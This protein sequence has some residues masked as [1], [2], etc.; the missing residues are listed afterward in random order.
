MWEVMRDDVP[1][2][3]VEGRWG[4]MTLAA[5]EGVGAQGWRP[6][7]EAPVGQPPLRLLNQPSVALGCL[8][9]HSLHINQVLSL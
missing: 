2:V 9:P 4:A 6:S 7:V 1:V 3:L 8:Q 5:G